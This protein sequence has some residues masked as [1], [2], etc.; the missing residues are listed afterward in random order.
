MNLCSGLG[1]FHF[2][3]HVC[4]MAMASFDIIN[5]FNEINDANLDDQNIH[6]RIGI[7]V[8]DCKAGIVNLSLYRIVLIGHV[9]QIAALIHAL[10]LR[11]FLFLKLCE[12]K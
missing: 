5:A 10:S 11:L 1:E 12:K 9:A 2:S 7:H 4:E 3:D 6:V 8:G